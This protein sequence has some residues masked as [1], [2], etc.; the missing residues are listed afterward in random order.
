M[1]E[2]HAPSE[3]DRPI[4]P[5]MRDL[6]NDNRL[7]REP[8]FN[9]TPLGV[10][11]VIGAI[12]IAHLALLV[13]GPQATQ[14]MASELGVVPARVLAQFAQGDILQALIP[15]IAHQFMHGG[16]LHL[17]M[18]IAMLLQAGPIAEIALARNKDGVAR[19]IVFFILCGVGGGLLYCWINPESQ[20]PTIGASGAISGIF[21]GFLWSALGL[22]KPG[23]RVLR[24]VITSA[25]VF[26]LINVGLA[27]VG[28]TLNVMPIAWE[29]HLGGFLSGLLL[30]PLIA[31]FGR[32]QK[33]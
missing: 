21:A 14:I 5:K 6:E 18:N 19:F 16:T 8:I 15:L 11:G 12:L 32:T 31:N 28:R 26:L 24:P 9:K 33:T 29:S 30:F 23:Q 2:R 3:G 7:P 1:E 13:A 17:V 27:W 4:D 22:A 20:I 25:A 10:G